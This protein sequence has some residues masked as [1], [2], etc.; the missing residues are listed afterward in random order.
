METSNNT[1]LIAGFWIRLLA[2]I[3]DAVFLGIFGF[4]LSL[5]FRGVF[6]RLGENGVWIGLLITFLYTGILQSA[7]GEGQSLAKRILKIQV[8]KMDGSF[9]SLPVSFLRYS[10]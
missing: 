3:L 10:V 5:L 1:K 7:V 4:L 8:L 6:L 9:L 2:D